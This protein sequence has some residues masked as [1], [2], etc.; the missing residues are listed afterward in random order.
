MNF[1]KHRVDL[2]RFT[3][4]GT[5]SRSGAMLKSE[6][7]FLADIP[8]SIQPWLRYGDGTREKKEGQTDESYWRI[9]MDLKNPDGTDRLILPTDN[10]IIR[11]APMPYL[12]DT[13]VGVKDVDGFNTFFNYYRITVVFGKING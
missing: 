9:Y 3:D 7:L 12:V 8:C 4:L 11:Q 1:S 5:K 6:N 2:Y 13:K 10:I